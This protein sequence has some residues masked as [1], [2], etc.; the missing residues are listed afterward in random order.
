MTPG[1]QVR[2]SGLRGVFTLVE[3]TEGVGWRM[4]RDGRFY[5]YRMERIRRKKGRER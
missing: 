2:V 1:D 5:A 3:E 4:Y